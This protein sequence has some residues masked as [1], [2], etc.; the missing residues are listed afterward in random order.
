MSLP[1]ITQAMFIAR[2]IATLPA[3]W[4]NQIA[5]QP[6][7][8]TYVFL[9]ATA[10][11]Y[12]YHL[13]SQLDYDVLQTRILTATGLNL[14]NISFDFL[15]NTLPRVPG[16]SDASYA[17]RIIAAITAPRATIASIQAA[18][19]FYFAN[20]YVPPFSSI[21]P[22]FALDIVGGFDTR[23]GLDTSAG[24][25]AL[26]SADIWDQQSDPTDATTYDISPPYFVVDIAFPIRA[27]TGWSLWPKDSYYKQSVLALSPASYL[28]MVA[29]TGSTEPNL[30]SDG[31]VGT[32][33]GTEVLNQAG[34]VHSDVSSA[35]VAFSGAGGVAI[36]ADTIRASGATY[37]IIAWL[38]SSTASQFAVVAEWN[39]F[40]ILVCNQARS[41]AGTTLNLEI[42]GSGDGTSVVTAFPADGSP[43]MIA[44]IYANGLWS[45]LVDGAVVINAVAGGSAAQN[46]TNTSSS[47][48]YENSGTPGMYF[49]GDI[50]DVAFIDGL[51]A[52][53]VQAIYAVA[54]A[55]TSFGALKYTT[56]L[57]NTTLLRLLPDDQI[58]PGLEQ[59][60]NE[61]KA[62]GCIP[63]YMYHS[64]IGYVAP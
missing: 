8:V 17:A 1:T 4:W 47:A 22:L 56:N 30:G 26:P 53:Q 44:A 49:T 63:V 2:F 29:L 11:A 38:N 7:G 62:E 46:H 32:Y 52:A 59:V 35:A 45:L 23:G 60:V 37:G 50:S 18:V 14:E 64:S 58:D 27:G 55:N 39:G 12:Y 41:G 10:A 48:G 40:R 33:V 31:G 54:I 43:H 13:N 15:G 51:T 9:I 61:Y 21:F 20:L 24:V 5:L 25:Q 6:G 16:E 42:V 57:V 36:P 3:R 28:R 19:N 34:L